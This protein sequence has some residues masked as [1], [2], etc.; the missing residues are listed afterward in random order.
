MTTL[1]DHVLYI[2]LARRRDRLAEITAELD[3]MGI[4][5]AVRLEALDTAP[6]GAIGC[7]YSHIVALREARAR[8]YPHVLILE[9]DAEFLVGRETLLTQLAAAEKRP[10]DVL[11]LA[12]NLRHSE[13]IDEIVSRTERSFTAS[14]YIVR[15]AYYTTLIE[16]LE[17][18][19]AN[20]VVTHNKGMYIN[21]VAWFRLQKRDQWLHMNTRIVRQRASYSDIEGVDVDYQV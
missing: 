18:S 4:Q 12:Y 13:E 6:L 8:G 17:R 16:C 14:A 20:L 19:F 1:L 9:D 11:L 15:A 5:G 2:N 21:D 7:T 3:R 10:W